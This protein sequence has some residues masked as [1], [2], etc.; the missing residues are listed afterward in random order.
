MNTTLAVW[1]TSDSLRNRLSVVGDS[2]GHFARMA[3][4]K[5]TVYKS[6]H[7]TLTCAAVAELDVGRFFQSDARPAGSC[8]AALFLKVFI[9][10]IE[11]KN[12][13]GPLFIGLTL[14]LPGAAHY[15]SSLLCRFKTKHS[16]DRCPNVCRLRILFNPPMQNINTAV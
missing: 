11:G 2:D 12:G 9:D 14:I 16:C 10:G 8:T 7:L 3:F 4:M 15:G 5:I 6:S 1:G 13:S